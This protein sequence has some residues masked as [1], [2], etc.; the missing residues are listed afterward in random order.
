MGSLRQ[1]EM[2]GPVCAAPVLG[3]GRMQASAASEGRNKYTD[4]IMHLTLYGWLDICIGMT[5]VTWLPHP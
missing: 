3:S 5:Y 2:P 1:L 4:R